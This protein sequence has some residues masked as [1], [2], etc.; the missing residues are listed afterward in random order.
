MA[1]VPFEARPSDDAASDK[2]YLIMGTPQADFD[3]A[4]SQ[5]HA[6]AEGDRLVA[7]DVHL[8]G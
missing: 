1:W 4:W 7:L 3:A 5:M 8:D 2:S 6:P